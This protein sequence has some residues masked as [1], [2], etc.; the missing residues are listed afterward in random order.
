MQTQTPNTLIIFIGTFST[1]YL[2]Q[3]LGCIFTCYL[4][5]IQFV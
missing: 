5:R 3:E 1:L 4:F 2:S